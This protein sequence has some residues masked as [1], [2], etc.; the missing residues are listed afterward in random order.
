MRNANVHRGAYT[1][2]VE[3]TDAYEGARTKIAAL[4]NAATPREVVFS[5]GTTSA[6]NTIAMGWGMHRLAAGDKILLTPL[7]HHSNIVPW[8]LVAR[9]T[10]AP[11]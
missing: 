8:Q 5:R 9:L 10:G 2:A 3:A 4:I 7:E 6:I 11:G 1:I